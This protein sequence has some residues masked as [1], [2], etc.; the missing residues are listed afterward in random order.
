ME[1]VLFVC[2][3]AMREKFP[4]FAAEGFQALFSRPPVIY[5][6]AAANPGLA[7]FLQFRVSSNANQHADWII[8]ITR[9][10]RSHGIELRD[11]L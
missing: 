7:D 8:A 4:K 10:S 11:F 3:L 1:G 6:S 5:L 9:A 2:R